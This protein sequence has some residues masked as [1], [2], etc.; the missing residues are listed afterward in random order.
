MCYSWKNVFLFFA[1]LKYIVYLCRQKTNGIDKEW[2]SN[3][4]RA[5]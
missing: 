1:V 5:G 3:R 4:L 2:R